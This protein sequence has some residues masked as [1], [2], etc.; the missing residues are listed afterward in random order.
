MAIVM[1]LTRGQD[2]VKE[3]VLE[4]WDMAKVMEYKEEEYAVVMVKFQEIDNLMMLA[5]DKQ[6]LVRSEDETC[7]L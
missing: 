2:M 5:K 7:W 6:V 4:E 1:R 3:T